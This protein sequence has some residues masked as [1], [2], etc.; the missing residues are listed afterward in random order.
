MAISTQSFSYNKIYYGLYCGEHVTIEGYIDGEF[1]KYINNTGSVFCE[2][3]IEKKPEVLFISHGRHQNF[4]TWFIGSRFLLCDPEIATIDLRVK[5]GG[6][7][8]Y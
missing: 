5:E 1:T 7:K 8:F 3:E 4:V 2:A 6:T